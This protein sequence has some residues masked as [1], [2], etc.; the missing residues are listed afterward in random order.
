MSNEC[1]VHHAVSHASMTQIFVAVSLAIAATPS[2]A[3]FTDKEGTTTITEAQT[4]ITTGVQA[5]DLNAAEIK[6]STGTESLTFDYQDSDE[7]SAIVHTAQGHGVFTLSNFA[8]V[9]FENHTTAKDSSDNSKTATIVAVGNYWGPNPI[10]ISGV[11]LLS[12]GTK[13]EAY[14]GSAV[15]ALAGEVDINV[16][17]LYI[18]ATGNGLY[19]QQSNNNSSVSS[20]NLN[21]EVADALVVHTASSPA[22]F[23]Q[24]WGNGATTNPTIAVKAKTIDILTDSSHAVTIQDYSQTQGA[25]ASATLKISAEDDI[26]IQSNTKD[27]VN[28][29]TQL[30]NESAAEGEKSIEINSKN[31]SVTINGGNNGITVRK[32]STGEMS[33]SVS[34]SGAEVSIT[35]QSASISADANA[36]V[37]LKSEQTNLVGN[38]AV[39]GDSTLSFAGRNNGDSYVTLAGDMT[40]EAGSTVT[41]QKT[42]FDLADGSSMNVNTL[43]GSE[44]S[45]ILNN[46]SNQKVTIGQNKIASLSLVA[47]GTANDAYGSASEAAA[48]LAKAATVTNSDSGTY[49]LTGQEGSVSNGWTASIDNEGNTTVTSVS[50]NASMAAIADFNAMTLAQWRGEINHLSQRLGD[51]RGHSTD[52]GTWVRV[53]GYDAEL[54]DTVA[55]DLKSNSIQVGADVRVGG[56]WVVGG[57]FSYTDQDADFSNG[58]GSS[59]GYALAAYAAGYFDCGGYID[60]IGRIGR[61][62]SDVSALS[63]GNSLFDG[64]YDNTTFGISVETGY[65]WNLNEAFYAEPQAELAYG[66][67]KGDDFTSST[68]GVKIEQDDFQSLVGRLGVRAG[69]DFSEHKGSVYLQAS[70]NHDFLGDADATATPAAGQARTISTDLGGT[71]FSY[72]FGLQYAAEN[73]INF[74]TSLERA[75]GSEYQENYRYNIGARYNF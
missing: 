16:G 3:I 9:H 41:L 39:K 46:L 70:V 49:A 64:S 29:V 18:N 30:G 1:K 47:S 62:S 50:E 40:S 6:G 17:N 19:L 63:K 15:Q 48:A 69:A 54:S 27:A 65:R 42:T 44:S 26:S 53:Y 73:G 74:Y 20:G 56:N 12:F 61:L 52:I 4:T 57:A 11:N 33:K 10:K 35:G 51:L 22:V 38:V 37:A 32:T 14:Y 66:F 13:E 23:V 36:D 43:T 59:D 2:Q 25:T 71:W 55:V 31:G 5:K 21:V 72:G 68:N 7:I 34:I 75:N 67:V 28:I 58:S 45:I 24:S 60:V 8:E